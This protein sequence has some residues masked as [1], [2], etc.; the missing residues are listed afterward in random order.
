ML[1]DRGMNHLALPPGRTRGRPPK[2]CRPALSTIVTPTGRKASPRNE[3][4]PPAGPG[5]A[6]LSDPGRPVGSDVTTGL[7]LRTLRASGPGASQVGYPRLGG[8]TAGNR[9]P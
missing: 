2:P 8:L 9:P 4:R 1:R 6:A 3:K 7:D 5:R